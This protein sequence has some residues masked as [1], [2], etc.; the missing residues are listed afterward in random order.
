MRLA[1]NSLYR[2]LKL[3]Y[4]KIYTNTILEIVCYYLWHVINIR[5]NHWTE[6]ISHHNL[7]YHYIKLEKWNI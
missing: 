7:K 5:N 4:S 1:T 3:S 2:A 6:N